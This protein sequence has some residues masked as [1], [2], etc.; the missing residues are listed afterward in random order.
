MTLPSCKIFNR[1]IYYVLSS[2]IL[3][4]QGLLVFWAFWPYD[5]LTIEELKVLNSSDGFFT[6][7]ITTNKK[8]DLPATVSR[9]FIDGVVIILPP[10]TTNLEPGRT[11]MYDKVSL[12]HA[13][14]GKYVF[15]WSATYKV[16]P[17]REIT[18]SATTDCFEVKEKNY[19]KSKN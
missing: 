11:E 12:Q 2:V 5:P 4:S 9:Q 19:E 14:P 6:Y 13:V 1:I 17:L 10:I 7:K 15:K 8:I 18:V 16:N 3:I